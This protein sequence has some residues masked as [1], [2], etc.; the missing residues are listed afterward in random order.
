MKTGTL[1]KALALMGA[2]GLVATVHAGDVDATI[3]ALSGD[4]APG[5]DPGVTFDFFDLARLDDAGHV[6]FAADVAGEDVDD[7]TNGTI[8]SDRTGTLSLLVREGDQAPFG[9]LVLYESLTSPAFNGSGL[10]AFGAA[11]D[12]NAGPEETTV[13]LFQ[14]LEQGFLVPFA[15]DGTTAPGDVI[16]MNLTP[17][18]FN[19]LG[20]SAFV[21]TDGAGLWVTGGDDGLIPIALAGE[22]LVGMPKGTQVMHLSTPTLAADGNVAF[23]AS[24]E[25]PA[26]EGPELLHGLWATGE[27]LL[28]LAAE[29]DQ[30]PGFDEG[31]TF[32]E[33]TRTPSIVAGGLAAFFAKVKGPGIDTSN[34]GAIWT[35]IPGEIETVAREGED[36]PD[37]DGAVFS[38]LEGRVALAGA[39]AVAFAAHVTGDEVTTQDNSGI[40]AG[41]PGSL[42]LLVREGDGVPGSPDLT[43]GTFSTPSMTDSGY[44]AFTAQLRSEGDELVP[45]FGLFLVSPSGSLSTVAL[46]GD[47]FA[48]GNEDKTITDLSFDSR[49]D[50]RASLGEDGTVLFKLYFEDRSQALV[51][52]SEGCFGDFNGDGVLNVLDFVDFQL[53]WQ[54][55]DPAADCDANGEFSV[56]D[57]ICFQLAWQAGCD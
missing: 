45:N 8:Y 57:F 55:Q 21:A 14:E 49:D 18:P 38:R 47:L 22:T 26:N 32:D 20:Q 40:W 9:N 5:L 27:G 52:A 46:E 7:L 56:L 54:A 28:K 33:V 13:G 4:Q 3:V 1:T 43:F 12:I 36:A 29:D 53:A 50:G 24:Y 25:L 16:L 35:G 48:V 2:A 51:M 6:L 37:I 19:D 10:Y 30:A 42:S 23:H 17:A 11:L 39:G 34:D 15:L 31:V 41:T 44:V